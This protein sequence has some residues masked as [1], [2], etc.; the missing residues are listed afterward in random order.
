VKLDEGAPAK[1]RLQSGD[2]HKG[3]CVIAGG[4]LHCE[5]TVSEGMELREDGDAERVERSARKSWPMQEVKAIEWLA[6]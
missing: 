4:W 6:A 3:R 1:V 5:V 2:R